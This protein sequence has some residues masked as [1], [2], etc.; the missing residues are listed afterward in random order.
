MIK[1]LIF[2]AITAFAGLSAWGVPACPEPA[3]I[4]Q[5]DGSVVTIRLIGDEFSNRTVTTDGYTLLRNAD[6]AYVYANLG[7]DGQLTPTTVVA[8][9]PALRTPA[10]KALLAN[11]G[12]NLRAQ[13]TEVQK[14]HRADLARMTSAGLPKGLYDYKK[15]KGLVILVNFTDRKFSYTNAKDIF[16]DMVC[17]KN[18]DGYM[19]NAALP[20]K[21]V[22]TGSVRDYF[23]DQSRGIFD[24]QF[25]VVG[26]V[27]INVSMTYPRQT[28]NM[29]SVIGKVIDAADDQVDF[30]KYDTNGD[31]TVDMF[32]VIFA[33]YGSNFSGNNSNYVWPHAWSVSYKYADGVRL[34]RYACS[35]ELYGRE[36]SS[37]YLDGIGT[38]CHEFSHVLGLKDEYDTDYEGS[39][40]Q[41][42]D[43]GDWSL[44]AGGSYLNKAR[45][46]VG[47]SLMQRYQS[48]FTVP[49]VVATAG[50]YTLRDIDATND[51]L[52]INLIDEPKEYFL[53]ENRRKTGNKWNCYGP[54]QGLLVFRVDSTNTNVWTS[55]DINVNPAHN[56]YE[57][58]R[59]H[60]NGSSDSQGDP[61]PGTYK[62]TQL[63]ADTDP[64]MKGWGGAEPEFGLDSIWEE[65]K[66]I[67]LRIKSDQGTTKF[68]DFEDMVTNGKY[69][70]NVQGKFTKW[71]FNN[72]SVETQSGN[73]KVRMVKGSSMTTAV[74][75]HG[76]VKRVSFEVSNP[77]GTTAY[78]QLQALKDGTMTPMSSSSG[79]I[80]IGVS[81]NTAAK[82]VSFKIP[83]LVN[84]RLMVVARAGS[85]TEP[86]YVDN[87]KVVKDY[88]LGV[89]TVATADN[90][91]LATIGGGVI[92]VSCEPGTQVGLFDVQ[93][94]L[95]STVRADES[96]LAELRPLTRGCYIIVAGGKALKVLF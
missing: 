68:E 35:T 13:R 1:K 11:L 24:P 6:G 79:T 58:I 23:Y 18:Y 44:M 86:I 95:L 62:V 46:P 26:P 80:Q 84:T 12:A 29:Q 30:S 8:H 33:G 9:D 10:E 49:K 78:L 34:G 50:E 19:N 64:A 42:V 73:K 41:S 5:P 14:Q 56:Y 88:E 16:T 89:G 94:R 21:E 53:L 69:D 71:T 17:K 70:E 67:H 57:L 54:G 92:S 51:G 81:P 39:G 4:T 7:V 52:R 15:F 43:P 55:N 72:A 93:G 45:T 82:A 48:G 96:G 74:I 90:A 60:Y 65:D 59:A 76:W 66:V 37:S 87:F 75:E 77:G 38:I 91:L 22:Y 2:T 31:G 28:S 3:R 61:F 20:S 47:Y 25:D 40:G 85:S 36:G 83:D 32:Y 27:D 63:N